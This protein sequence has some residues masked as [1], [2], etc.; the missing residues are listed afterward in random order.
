MSGSADRIAVASPGSRQARPKGRH[1]RRPR[2]RHCRR[3]GRR[4]RCT[5]LMVGAAELGRGR[6]R[7]SVSHWRD[8]QGFAEYI[9]TVFP[10][11]TTPAPL[12]HGRSS[13]RVL[14]KRKGG[15]TGSDQITPPLAS[16]GSK[17]HRPVV[18]TQRRFS[19]R[20]GHVGRKLGLYQAMADNGA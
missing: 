4:R 12:E 10:L 5:G 15:G 9:K 6:G 13:G 1:P 2:A 7:L 20:A 18:T 16:G 11:P 3:R 17:L 19:G 14:A 8:L